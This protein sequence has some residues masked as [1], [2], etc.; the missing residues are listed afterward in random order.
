VGRGEE[1]VRFCARL[2]FY[3]PS[4]NPHSTGRGNKHNAV[5]VKAPYRTGTT[6]EIGGLFSFHVIGNL[7]QKS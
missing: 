1:R 5:K 2:W 4:S 7:L 6:T 3:I